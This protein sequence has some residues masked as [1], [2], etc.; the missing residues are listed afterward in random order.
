MDTDDVESK[1][2]A[3]I[4]DVAELAGPLVVTVSR[5]AQLRVGMERVARWPV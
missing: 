5:A 4:G 3:T 2:S 1:D